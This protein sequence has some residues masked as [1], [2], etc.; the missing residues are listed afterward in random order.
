M[1]LGLGAAT[2]LQRGIVDLD[3]PQVG[4]RA[5]RSLRGRGMRPHNEEQN[6]RHDDGGDKPVLLSVH[7]PA[8]AGSLGAHDRAALGC[9][10]PL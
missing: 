5:V 2:E 9:T 4:R 10:R 7:R 8:G 3:V 1:Q 6:K